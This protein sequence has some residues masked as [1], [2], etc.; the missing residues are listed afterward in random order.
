MRE[1]CI[2]TGGA[3]VSG[4]TTLVFVRAAAAPAVNIEFLRYWIGQSANATSAQ[5]RVQL[6]LNSGT[7]T[8]TAYTPSKIKETD[9]V[10]SITGSTTPAAGNTTINATVETTRTVVHEDAFNVLNGWLYVATPPETRIQPAGAT[11]G[12]TLYLP[13]A[14]STLT[15]WTWGLNYREV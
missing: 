3:T 10:S 7:V 2:T 13:V 15:N 1:F 12:F 5:Q 8:G 4:T 6:A 11:S 14:P 9:A